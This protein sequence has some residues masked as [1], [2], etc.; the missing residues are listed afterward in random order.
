LE[1]FQNRRIGSLHCLL[2]SIYLQKQMA[3][4]Y[5][6]KIIKTES[7]EGETFL[8]RFVVDYKRCRFKCSGFQDYGTCEYFI[9]Q[10]EVNQ[11]GLARL[12]K[13]DDGKV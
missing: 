5:F 3:R 12:I 9:T 2:S 8:K 10:E 11:G 13:R 6:K 4:C 1:R 7:V